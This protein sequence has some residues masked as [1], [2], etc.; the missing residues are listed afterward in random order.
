[1]SQKYDQYLGQFKNRSAKIPWKIYRKI[2]ENEYGAVETKRSHSGGSKRTFV[3]GE[4]LVFSLHKP[5]GKNDPVGKWD[6]HNVLNLFEQNGLIE[7]ED[8]S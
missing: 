5:H 7:D 1:M 6:H 4:N 2:L 3:I 8:A